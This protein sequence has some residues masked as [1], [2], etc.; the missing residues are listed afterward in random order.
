MWKHSVI[1]TSHTSIPAPAPDTIPTMSNMTPHPVLPAL[2][3][4]DSSYSSNFVLQKLH[5]HAT[6]SKNS[7]Y[8]TVKQENLGKCPILNKGNLNAKNACQY[9]DSCNGYFDVKDI[10]E[11]KKV[12]KVIAG[13]HDQQMKDHISTNRAHIIALTFP[14][15]LQELKDNWLNKNQEAITHIQLLHMVQGC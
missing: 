14:Q 7:C 5:N 6:M 13:I 3:D 1:I 12:R 15:F 9:D 2:T 4:S 10:P 8:A 11:D